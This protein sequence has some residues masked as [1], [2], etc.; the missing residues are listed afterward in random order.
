[1]DTLTE[2]NTVRSPINSPEQ[3]DMVGISPEIGAQPLGDP[4]TLW[5]AISYFF[6]LFAFA[7]ICDAASTILVMIRFGPGI[8]LHPVVR[9]LSCAAGPVAGPLLGAGFKAIGA[10]IITLHWRRFAA[11]ILSLASAL[12]FVATCYNIWGM[13][14][15]LAVQ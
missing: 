2:E 8:E 7:L 4:T 12:Y 14:G 6:V 11:C 3:D 1:M 5:P 9:L 15:R 13:Y 10:I